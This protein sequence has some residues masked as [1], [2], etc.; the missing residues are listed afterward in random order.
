[1]YVFGVHKCFCKVWP[2]IFQNIFIYMSLALLLMLD[3]YYQLYDQYYKQGGVC[4]KFDEDNHDENV[5]Q[6]YAKDFCSR[7]TGR[8]KLSIHSDRI[9]PISYSILPCI[10]RIHTVNIKTCLQNQ[11]ISTYIYKFPKNLINYYIFMHI[12]FCF[13]VY[14][15]ST[16]CWL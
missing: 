4:P 6:L 15:Q 11:L 7:P 1:M 13:L 9:I 12:I 14:K 2:N 3:N 16:N 10:P 5:V 8:T